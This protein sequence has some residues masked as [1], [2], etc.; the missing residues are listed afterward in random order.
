MHVV[1]PIHLY[2]H[3]RVVLSLRKRRGSNT[4]WLWGLHYCEAWILNHDWFYV[5]SCLWSS[6]HLPF[7]IYS[8]KKLPL[9]LH[10]FNFSFFGSVL[11]KL[12]R[13]YSLKKKKWHLRKEQMFGVC[14]YFVVF[15]F[16]SFFLFGPWL[17]LC[18]FGINTGSF[19]ICVSCL[20]WFVVGVEHEEERDGSI[21][22]KM[23]KVMI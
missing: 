7:W 1:C 5:K 14:F 15:F 18:L 20:C 21:P 12:L 23:L 19:I 4:F 3:L 6:L 17:D 11:L 22:K 16:F 8:T 13:V 9:R 10:C 2:L